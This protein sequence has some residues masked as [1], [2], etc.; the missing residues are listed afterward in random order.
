[1]TIYDH[2]FPIRTAYTES[3][4]APSIAGKGK[5]RKTVYAAPRPSSM[6]RSLIHPMARR[7]RVAGNVLVRDTKV[8]KRKKRKKA[9]K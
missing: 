4:N 2:V 9:K 1:M 7:N 6:I 3:N 8:K 5:I